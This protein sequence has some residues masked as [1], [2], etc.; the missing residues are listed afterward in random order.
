MILNNL[1]LFYSF[2]SRSPFGSLEGVRA[3]A[4]RPLHSSFHDIY[5]LSYYTLDTCKDN[6]LCGIIFF[7]HFLLARPYALAEVEGTRASP[8]LILRTSF[9]SLICNKHKLLQ[10]LSDF[11]K[12]IINTWLNNRTTCIHNSIFI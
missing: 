2:F 1:H 4:F 12:T 11:F 5:H 7:F 9:L 3:R 10:E 6:Y 8:L